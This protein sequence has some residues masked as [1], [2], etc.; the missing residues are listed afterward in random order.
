VRRGTK[1][2]E[3]QTK[4]TFAISHRFGGQPYFNDFLSKNYKDK[5]SAA[6]GEKNGK[7]MMSA[8]AGS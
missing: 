7:A 5:F 1:A 4:L 2:G 3:T 6:F 8:T